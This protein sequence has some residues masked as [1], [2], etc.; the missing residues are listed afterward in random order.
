MIDW[1]RR[2]YLS[3]SAF[4]ATKHYKERIIAPALRE[5]LGLHVTPL[6]DFDTDQFGTFSGERPR[7]GSA[8]EAARAKIA[9]GFSQSSR[10]V[11]LASEGSFGPDP[12][13]PLVPIGREIVL[14]FDFETGLE[15]I[16]T[17]TDHQPHFYH[18][19]VSNTQ[20]ATAFAQRVDF[21]DH[22]VIVCGCR[23]GE[24]HPESFL[25][26]EIADLEELNSAVE[27]VLKESRTAFLQTDMR[28]HRNPTRMKAIGKATEDLA[29]RLQSRC[30]DCRCPG[31]DI[32]EWRPGR[33]C[34]WCGLPTCIVELEILTCQN[35]GHRE[36][37]RASGPDRV[38]P[39]V[40]DYCNP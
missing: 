37:R 9:A 38:D 18:T 25:F 10:P 12:S 28:A 6:T 29:R 23:D 14:F 40:C 17:A 3:G 34:D 2:S 11:G 24:P 26:K 30:P 20:E 16:G 4:L 7:T 32:I 22:G 5:S 21:P 8:I 27:C 35:C 33:P 39:A 36:E 31:Y 1:S 13:L 19:S 15:V